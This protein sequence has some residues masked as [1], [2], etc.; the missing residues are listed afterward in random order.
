MT[1]RR[2]YRW[3]ILPQAAVVIVPPLGNE[4][5]GMIK[6]TSLVVVIGGLDIF[7]A[8][9]Q[10]N[11]TLFRPFELFLAVSCY[12]LALTMA[13]SWIQSRIE[14]RLGRSRVRVTMNKQPNFPTRLFAGVRS[15]KVSQ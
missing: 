9:E 3:I 7:N 15:A 10:L 5:N 2:A 1:S 12:Y 14:R 13:W 4:F 8:Y 6:N 11:G